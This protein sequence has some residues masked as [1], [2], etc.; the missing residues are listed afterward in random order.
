MQL[1]ILAR[2]EGVQFYWTQASGF[3]ANEDIW[4]L[5]NVALLYSNE[6]Y[7]PLLST[8]SGLEQSSLVMFYTGGNVEVVVLICM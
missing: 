3:H 1:P 2:G 4:Q 7:L 6:I 8:F 5:D